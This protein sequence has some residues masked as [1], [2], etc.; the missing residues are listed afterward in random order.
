MASIGPEPQGDFPRARRDLNNAVTAHRKG[1][2][3]FTYKQSQENVVRR[4]LTAELLTAG[5]H[6]EHPEECGA[7]DRLKSGVICVQ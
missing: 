1:P 6:D 2:P 7:A 4:H 3:G 5:E